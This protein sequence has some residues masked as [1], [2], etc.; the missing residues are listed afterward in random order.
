VTTP[1]RATESERVRLRLLNQADAA[2]VQSYRSS[3]CVA[4]YQSWE[5]DYS[6]KQARDLVHQS[7]QNSFGVPGAWTQLAIACLESDVVIGDI[8]VLICEQPFR[9]AEIGYSLAPAYQRVGLATE[10]LQLLLRVLAERYKV[11]SV[12]ART[13]V[14]NEPSRR[15]LAR[16]GFLEGPVMERNGFYKGEWVDE[17]EYRIGPVGSVSQA[18]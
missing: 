8:G 14:R 13:D 12:K 4:R 7:S 17:V 18:E 1:F 2:N 3:E 11:H 10:A 5:T 16:L 15:L 9:F 6:L